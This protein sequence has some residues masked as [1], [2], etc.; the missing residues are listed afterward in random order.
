VLELVFVFSSKLYVCLR[1]RYFPIAE[2]YRVIMFNGASSQ[3]KK[4]LMITV[5]GCAFSALLLLVGQQE[6]HP[7]C[8]KVSGGV[9]AWL[10]VWNNVQT[11]I[12]PS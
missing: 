5:I 6:G 2:M 4:H 10:S 12:W 11:C 8:K 3:I 9:L 1:F 7:A